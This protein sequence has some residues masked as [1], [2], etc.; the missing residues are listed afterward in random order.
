MSLLTCKN[1]QFLLD[2]EPF[3]IISG[4]MHYF[5]VLPEYW[6]DRMIKLK[7]M[8]CNTLETYVAWKLHE[9]HEGQFHFEDNLDLVRYIKLAEEIGLKVIVRPG[10]YI[11]AEFDFG[12]LPAWLLKDKAIQLRCSNDTYLSK[13]DRYFDVLIEKLIPLQS[14]NGGPVIA[15]QVENEYG[16]YGDDKKYLMHLKEGLIR[17]GIDVLLFTSDNPVDFMLQGGSLE[18][19]LITLNFGSNPIDRFPVLDEYQKDLPYMCMEYWNGW[20]DSW[21]GKH[22]PGSTAEFTATT[23]D[24]MLRMGASVNFYMFHGGTSFGFL[25]GANKS[26]TSYEPDVT[27]Y[28]YG[29]LLNEVGDPTEKYYMCREVISQYVKGINT[30][31]V[32]PESKKRAY[33]TVVLA[34]ECG[35]FEALNSLSYPIYNTTPLTMED[36]GQDMGYIHYRTT[37]QGPRNEGNF[38]IQDYHDRALLFVDGKYVKTFEYNQDYSDFKLA[39]EKEQTTIDILVESMGRTNYGPYMKD[40]KGVTEGV[41]FNTQFLF[42]WEMYSLPLSNLSTLVFS[43]TQKQTGPTFYRGYFDVED[44]A[45]TFLKLANCTKGNAFVN[46]FHLG[47]YWNIGPQKT[48]YIPAPLLK[49]GKNELI[50]FELYDITVPSVTLTDVHDLGEM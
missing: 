4:A 11:C 26:L 10:P 36:V 5:R 2:T 22:N 16:A 23:L 21:G 48:L 32:Y 14:T 29:A 44:I 37:I 41:R 20:F 7:E 35:L 47:R 24:T 34:E 13:V 25:G 49:A 12:G 8:G 43:N 38:T 40:Y 18:D 19:V 45:D 3:Q 50:I 28:D 17:R 31:K 39:F 15:I 27:S 6:K 46:G 1:K 9:P 30:S 33:G 42:H